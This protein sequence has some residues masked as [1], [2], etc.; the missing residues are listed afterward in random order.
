MTFYHSTFLVAS[1]ALLQSAQACRYPR[2][3]GEGQFIEFNYYCDNMIYLVGSFCPP[4]TYKKSNCNL[5]HA[6]WDEPECSS[7]DREIKSENN[8]GWYLAPRK[9]IT[10]IK[11]A[12]KDFGCGCG[13][14]PRSCEQKC[15]CY[16]EL[17]HCPAGF[18]LEKNTDYHGNNIECGRFGRAETN[19]AASACR[20][21]SACRG[22]SLRDNGERYNPWCLKKDLAYKTSRTDHHFCVKTSDNRPRRLET[23]EEE[24]YIA[25]TA[26]D[27]PQYEATIEEFLVEEGEE[28]TEELDAE[29]DGL[30]ATLPAEEGTDTPIPADAP[31]PLAETLSHIESVEQFCEFARGQDGLLDVPCAKI[32]RILGELL[33]TDLDGILDVCDGTDLKIGD[34]CDQ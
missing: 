13:K 5:R 16:E 34:L 8:C 22:F 33:T 3:Y 23:E 20:Q 29:L 11:P 2:D 14:S 1:M 19:E 6:W 24:E 15:T 10:C 28:L 21:N 32:H 26:P 9:T 25:A 30:T 4:E 31:V 7:G 17:Q 27:M 18:R 12:L